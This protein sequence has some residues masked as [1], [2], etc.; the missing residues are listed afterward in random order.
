MINFQNTLIRCSSLGAILTEPLSASD[1]AAGMLSKTAK[2]C[3]IKTYIS[4]VYGR[5]KEITSKQMEKGTI[6]EE[7][8]IRSLS[9]FTGKNLTKNLIQ[10]ENDWIKGTPDIVEED[11]VWDTKLS[12]DIWTFLANVTEPLD[13]GYLAQLQGYMWLTGIKSGSV[14]Y[15]LEDCPQHIIDS[16]KFYLLKKMNVISEESPEYI[17]AA[18]GIEINLI[19]PDIPPES[20]I[21]MFKVDSDDEMIDKM[22]QKITKCREFLQE[23]SE[24]HK[25]FNNGNR[26]I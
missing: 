25:N 1:K 24:K 8:G 19:Y 23:F 11:Y 18:A 13:K 7:G 5:D 15:L 4:E 3:L 20:K 22:K 21:L 9:R 14:T 26:R 17:E 6:G 10:F 12:F 2:T 16:E